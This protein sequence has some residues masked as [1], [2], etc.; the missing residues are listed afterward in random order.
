MQGE[1][2]ETQR[3]LEKTWRLVGCVPLEVDGP[4]ARECR[5]KWTGRPLGIPLEGGRAETSG[6]SETSGMWQGRACA[7]RHLPVRSNAAAHCHSPVRSKCCHA[8]PLAFAKP[9]S[10]FLVR[11]TTPGTLPEVSEVPAQVPVMRSGFAPFRP[12]ARAFQPPASRLPS[13]W[14]LPP[15]RS[16]F[17]PFRPQAR[18]NLHT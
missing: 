15:M 11:S 9:A 7:P 18:A 5:W 17:A 10:L 1:T 3:L 4:P 16:G 2:Q 12:Q 6:T 8:T 13:P 14:P